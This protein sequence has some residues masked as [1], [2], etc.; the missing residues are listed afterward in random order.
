MTDILT[1]L[2]RGD[3]YP[4]SF[5][6]KKQVELSEQLA[7]CYSSIERWLVPDFLDQMLDLSEQFH[8]ISAQTAFSDG[9]RLGVQ[10]MLETLTPPSAPSPARRSDS[11]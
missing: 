9:F 6:T 8:E 4:T 5:L 10:L 2:Y 11:P 1:Q 7:P 3:Y